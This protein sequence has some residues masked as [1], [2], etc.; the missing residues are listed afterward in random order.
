MQAAQR[1]QA[2]RVG[3]VAAPAPLRP[4]LAPRR[5]LTV[6]AAVPA[7]AVAVP[8]K[9]TDGADAGS[10]NMALGVAKEASAKGLVHR[11]LV[12]VRQNAR[13]VRQ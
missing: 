4:S 1:L 2:A 12:Y 9:T 13:R 5:T 7:A 3:R 10:A 6:R 11:Y 8:V